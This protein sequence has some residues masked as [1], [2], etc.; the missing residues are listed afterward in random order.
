MDSR[1]NAQ[2]EASADS[3]PPHLAIGLERKATDDLIAWIVEDAQKQATQYLY[4]TQVA[5]DGE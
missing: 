5:C 1:D 3:I 4:E 2:H